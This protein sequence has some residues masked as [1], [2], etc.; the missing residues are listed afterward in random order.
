MKQWKKL[1]S[2]LM[3][4]VFLVGIISSPVSAATQMNKLVEDALT[5]EQIEFVEVV[6]GSLEN[7]TDL[8]SG[9]PQIKII[10]KDKLKSEMDALSSDIMTFEELE[11][12]ISNFNY[13]MSD[14]EN[15]LTELVDEYKVELEESEYQTMG[16][17]CSDILSIIGL[18]HS[19]NY[20]L[21]AFLLG[22]TGPAA[23]IVP[24]LVAAAYTAGSVIGCKL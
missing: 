13:Y 19:G 4:V 7:Y 5:D 6:M 18:I 16:L 8:S 12:T 9:N 10:D 22:V 14:G 20:A 1:T 21:A 24:L 17:S 2:L 15:A 11:A 23:V 3:A